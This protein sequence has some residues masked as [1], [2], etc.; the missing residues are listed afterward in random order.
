MELD[1]WRPQNINIDK[2]LYI[3]VADA[4][5]QDIRA[6]VL[7]PGQK[8]PTQRELSELIGANLST[9]TRAFRE[10]ELR[11]LIS[12]T[13]GRGTYVASDI[14]VEVSLA[15]SEEQR[16][17]L[18]EMGL[19]L[20]LYELDKGT[21]TYIDSI[22]PTID[23]NLLLRYT[24]PSGLLIHRELG[25]AWVNRFGLHTT[26]EDILVTAGSQNALACCLM[27]LFNA[28]DHIAVDALTYPGIKTL[29]SMTGIRL[30][31]IEMDEDGMSPDALSVACRKGAIRGIY[32]MPE[33]Q[34]PTTSSMTADRRKQIAA[35]IKQYNLILIEDD[36]YGYTGSL[37]QTALSSLV[38]NH[39]I[40]IAGI[41]KLLGAGFRISFAAVPRRFKNQ[42][43]K[44]ILNTI[45]M[46][47]PINA[48]IVS[49][50][51]MSGK[52]ETIMETKRKEA[53]WRTALALEKLSSYT[54]FSRANGFFLWLLLPYE[55]TGR[56]FELSAREAGV[57][58]FCAEK[59]AVGSK[60]VP[61]AVRISLTGPET[62]EDL[63][64]GLDI[65]TGI[66]SGGYRK[67]EII[68]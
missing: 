44:A 37:K 12:A 16:S 22:L 31:P 62:R 42:I 27:S 51:L 57:R 66:L 43:E 1:S 38:P 63:R 59:F 9:I 7:K 28:G 10:C 13:V 47:S 39:G 41:S 35:I 65:L 17:D 2:P 55:W 60:H 34:N 36:A 8:L 21:V 5:E 3:A 18:L 32:L 50:L 11:G 53:S 58:V 49:K 48:E 6:G 46:A 67:S 25:S 23:L 30:V 19:V 56:D 45:W 24:Q 29:S 52:G 61:S 40:Y 15:P 14:N 68:F 26:S 33:V 20:P 54:I 64:Q 4:L